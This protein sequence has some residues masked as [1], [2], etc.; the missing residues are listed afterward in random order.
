MNKALPETDYVRIPKYQF[1]AVPK[2]CITLYDLILK[3]HGRSSPITGEAGAILK[4]IGLSIVKIEDV[5]A[6]KETLH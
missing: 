6:N 4:K 1:E 5:P 3:H 2:S